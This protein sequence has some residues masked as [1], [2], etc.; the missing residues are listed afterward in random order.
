[1]GRPSLNSQN[2]PSATQEHKRRKSH[3]SSLSSA[4]SIAGRTAPSMQ[5]STSSIGQESATQAISA[6]TTSSSDPYITQD[7]FPFLV[8]EPINSLG[9]A[10]TIG[11]EQAQTAQEQWRHVIAFSDIRTFDPVFGSDNAARSEPFPQEP[12]PSHVTASSDLFDFHPPF[13]M[14]EPDASSS[15]RLADTPSISLS[16]A[17]TSSR[18]T[19]SISGAV[20]SE[21]SMDMILD[22]PYVP[23]DSLKN[24]ILEKLSALSGD[25]LQDLRRMGTDDP[26]DPNLISSSATVV[27]SLL[28]TPPPGEKH[29]VGRMLEHSEQFLDILQHVAESPSHRPTSNSLGSTI[30]TVRYFNHGNED[31]NMGFDSR[32]T[33]TLSQLLGDGFSPAHL[34]A[35]GS[36]EA[37]NAVATQSSSSVIR[38]D[39]PTMLAILTCYTCLIRL[40]GR[41]F[42]YIQRVL[43][44]SP[45]ARQKLLPPFPGLHLCG[46]KLEQHQN[47]QLEILSRVSLHMLGRIEKVLEDIGRSCVSSGIM[48]ESL[49]ANLLNMIIKQNLDVG[50]NGTHKDEGSLKEITTSIK[51][52]LEVRLSVL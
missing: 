16:T 3:I 26:V 2:D 48:E 35:T 39:I 46:F 42:S 43:N 52:L 33:A 15:S 14:P 23:A 5:E 18:E 19:G 34:A 12:I 32:S 47:L 7:E 9:F 28:A 31:R 37:N 45:S 8:Q 29:N 11:S 10:Q 24:D 17:G 13:T 36:T 6:P 49:A 22:T 1:M 4:S 20:P 50:L 40:Y 41:V 51:E 44:A 21:N 27:S 38:P 25:L 30:A